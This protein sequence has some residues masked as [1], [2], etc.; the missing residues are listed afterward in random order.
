MYLNNICI[1][2]YAI[3]FPK[4]L[5]V[6]ALQTGFFNGF[7][8]QVEAQLIFKSISLGCTNDADVFINDFV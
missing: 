8:E 5:G 2:L 7:A 3:L 4:L 6:V 1:C